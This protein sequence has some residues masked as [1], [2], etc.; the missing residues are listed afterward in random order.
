MPYFIVPKSIRPPSIA[1]VNPASSLSEGLTSAGLVTGNTSAPVAHDLVSNTILSSYGATAPDLAGHPEMDSV[2]RFN[3]GARSG[4]VLVVDHL[5]STWLNG[6]TNLTVFALVRTREGLSGSDEHTIA[7]QW[8]DT[9]GSADA[10]ARRVLFRYD[11]NLDRIGFFLRTASATPGVSPNVPGTFDD[12]AW[13]WIVGRYDGANISLWYDGVSIA[14]AAQTAAVQSASHSKK[15]EVLG[16]HRASNI[17]TDSGQLDLKAWGFWDRAI[18]DTE[19][20][21]LY[22]PPTRWDL[23][24]EPLSRMYFLPVVAAPAGASV[25]RLVNGGLVNTGL[26]NGGLVA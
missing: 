18:S 1:Q 15:P 12:L 10:N 26:I 16:C 7:G 14:S 4:E 13:H 6:S 8:T 9:Q 19:I 23:F 11:P 22:A 20:E 3:D 25:R 5:G 2:L 24:S 21:A 17:G